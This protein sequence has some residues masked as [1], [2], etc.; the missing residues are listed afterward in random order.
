MDGIHHLCSTKPSEAPWSGLRT[1][2]WNPAWCGRKLR[3][4]SGF[5]ERRPHGQRSLNTNS[6]PSDPS[7][8]WA[9]AGMKRK[10]EA[11]NSSR[12]PQKQARQDPVSCQTCRKRKLK[13]DR[14]SPCASCS[15]RGLQCIY[16]SGG[17]NIDQP[18]VPRPPVYSER[19]TELSTSPHLTTPIAATAN[20]G[21][22]RTP[23][24]EST[25]TVERLETMIMGQIS[26]DGVPLE[27]EDAIRPVSR[28][29]QSSLVPSLV[30]EP[31]DLVLPEH[32]CPDRSPN[33]QHMMPHMPT[34]QEALE[35]FGYY[36][37]RLDWQYHI[38]VPE[39]VKEQ[40]H[41]IYQDRMGESMNFHHAALLFAIAASA[42]SYRLQD[43][44]EACSDVSPSVGSYAF[45]AGDT[46]LRGDY[47]A[48]PTIEGLQAAMIIGHHIPATKMPP[49]ISLLFS[50]R[51]SVHQ[52][53]SMGLHVTDSPGHQHQNGRRDPVDLE[54]RR[55]LW[56]DLVSYDW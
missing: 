43:E 46:L 10:F 39:R 52:A 38:I 9:T 40:I 51:T 7:P 32:A 17:L 31:S 41:G 25:T 15:A 14:K 47:L 20:I 6:L 37:D 19:I 36:C 2:Q 30:C 12:M 50:H 28:Q 27:V 42:A 45:Y 54:L 48:S 13:C 5:L 44:P 16:T 18:G 23:G 26:S 11:R 1:R 3:G 35:L 21:A 24:V 34:R 29:A 56:W 33:K 22:H 53:M 55:R 4:D 49:A 8:T